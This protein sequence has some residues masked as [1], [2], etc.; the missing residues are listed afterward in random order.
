MFLATNLLALLLTVPTA[1]P[2]VVTHLEPHPRLTVGD[3]FDLALVLTAPH[4]SLVTGPLADSTGVFQVAGETRKSKNDPE[5]DVTTYKLSLAGFEPGVH[6]VPVF[7]FVVRS[8]ARTDTVTSDTA[9]VTIASVLPD[10][11]KA[12]NGIK[13]AEEFP[14]WWLWL[15]P[16]GVILAGLLAW[17][18]RRLYRRLKR[19]REDSLAPLPPWEEALAA[20]DSLP[21]RDWLQG[22]EIK[23]YYYALSE[24]LKRYI[25]RRFDFQAAEQT[26]TEIMA[27]MR[28]HRVPMRDEI[29]R[30][31]ERTDLVKYAKWSPPEDEALAA[32]DR[33]R[34]F[35]VKTRPEAPAPAPAPGKAPPATPAGVPAPA[36]GS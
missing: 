13:P 36:Q 7:S 6:A 9:S 20:L 17:A 35:V 28:V 5:H 25:E 12:I 30:F 24:V 8:G 4:Q 23:R 29:R 27:S 16:V 26:T 2:S 15:I 11:M 18:G 34:E 14:N 31:F 22:G 10:S 1:G 32:I 19:L 21:W 3:R 33:V